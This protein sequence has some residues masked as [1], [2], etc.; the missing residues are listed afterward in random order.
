[1]RDY[2][3]TEL[4][5]LI[6]LLHGYAFAVELRNRG[7]LIG[8]QQAE[9]IAYFKKRRVTFVSV[10]G[11]KSEHFMV[12]P[13]VDVVTN[14]RLAYLRAHGRNE[15][16]YITG[17]TVAERFDYDYSPKELREIAGRAA[18][19]AEIAG[20]THII[21]NNNKS[22]YAPKAAARFRRIVEPAATPEPVST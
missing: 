15:H 6:E 18:E 17:R 19:M 20:T 12:M 7:W 13:A 14:P 16:G 10:D 4:D 11:P 1:P 8:D 21:F 3:L 9:T 22:S 2:F 5:H